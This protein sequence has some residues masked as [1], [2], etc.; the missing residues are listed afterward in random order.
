M[1]RR[2]GRPVLDD[3]R[4]NAVSELAGLPMFEGP[5]LEAADHER[6][7]TALERVRAYLADGSWRTLAEIAAACGCS[8]AGASARLRD[9]RKPQ[10]GGLSVASRRRTP[11]TWEYRLP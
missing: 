5:H 4:P 10:Y 6:L 1:T 9:L 2:Y 7:A 8:E 3:W 11:G